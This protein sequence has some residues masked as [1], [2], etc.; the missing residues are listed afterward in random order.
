MRFASSSARANCSS[1]VMLADTAGA[2]DGA[3]I[4]LSPIVQSLSNL[5]NDT[6]SASAIHAITMRLGFRRPRSIPPR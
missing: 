5:G 3:K 1:T 6:P 4:A 2:L